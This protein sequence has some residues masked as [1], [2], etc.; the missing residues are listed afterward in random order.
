M[1]TTF[2]AIVYLSFM[3]HRH[4]FLRIRRWEEKQC[5]GKVSDRDAVKTIASYWLIHSLFFISVCCVY[6]ASF[7]LDSFRVHWAGW[8]LGSPIL[9]LSIYCLA[10]SFYDHFTGVYA[11]CGRLIKQFPKRCLQKLYR[12]PAE[13]KLSAAT[14]FIEKDG[15]FLSYRTRDVLFVRFIAEQLMARGIPVWFDEYKITLDIKEKIAF[16]ESVFSSIIANAAETSK[17]AICFTNPDYASSDYC[18]EEAMRLVERLPR[19]KI[20]NIACPDHQPLYQHIPRMSGEPL[21]QLSS[22]PSKL[23]IPEV[24]KAWD[25]ILRHLEVDVAPLRV[26]LPESEV[27]TFPWQKGVQYSLDLGGWERD[28]VECPRKLVELD[29]EAGDFITTCNKVEIRLWACAGIFMG[30]RRETF[31]TEESRPFYFVKVGKTFEE[32]LNNAEYGDNIIG[33]HL[34]NLAGNMNCV[35]SHYDYLTNAWC[36][37]YIIVFDNPVYDQ[38]KKD[39]PEV[40][41]TEKP[42]VGRELEISLQFRMIDCSFE[43]FCS[44]AYL[45]DRVASSVMLHQPSVDSSV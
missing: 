33:L 20:L 3:V 15:V 29:R 40:W 36:R 38:V 13:K 44:A 2:I 5:L 16:D 12:R 25:G 43:E 27:K 31:D 26:M 8:L 11:I 30:E 10:A 9:L 41:K 7:T 39:M 4:V 34:L 19:N 45:M 32:Y 23:D 24:Q 21:V 17:S 18:K 35:I 6:A 22:V 14:A 42:D 1:T 28:L 37:H